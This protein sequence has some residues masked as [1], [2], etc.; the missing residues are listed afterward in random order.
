MNGYKYILFTSYICNIK[1]N[2][3]NSVL[4]LSFAMPWN[5]FVNYFS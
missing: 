5:C 1:S 3:Y 4:N 2:K